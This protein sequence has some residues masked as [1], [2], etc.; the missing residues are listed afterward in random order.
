LK[1]VCRAKGVAVVR[2]GWARLSNFV[3][4]VRADC[5]EYID[6]YCKNAGLGNGHRDEANKGQA[7]GSERSAATVLLFAE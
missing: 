2:G 3:V 1:V 7:A 4:E 5:G 6:A